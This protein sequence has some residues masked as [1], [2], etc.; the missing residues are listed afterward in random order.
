MRAGKVAEKSFKS[1]HKGKS[2]AEWLWV[3]ACDW[4]F[5]MKLDDD[6]LLPFKVLGELKHRFVSV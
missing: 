6:S 2:A 1:T 4:Q 3:A 5:A